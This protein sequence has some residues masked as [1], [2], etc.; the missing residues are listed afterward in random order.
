MKI[1]KNGEGVYRSF[2]RRTSDN[3]HRRTSPAF[4]AGSVVLS[5]FSLSSCYLLSSFFRVSRCGS[6]S[7]ERVVDTLPERRPLY[8]R[9]PEMTESRDREVGVV[10]VSGSRRR[11]GGGGYLSCQ[12]SLREEMREWIWGPAS[13]YLFCVLFCER[14]GETSFFVCVCYE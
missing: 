7:P 12:L 2:R 10:C 8:L 1:K 11:R 3:H 14:E 4:D 6:V 9:S 5:V 13:P